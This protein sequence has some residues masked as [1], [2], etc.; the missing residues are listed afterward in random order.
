MS[1]APFGTH[2]VRGHRQAPLRHYNAVI[3]I[4]ATSVGAETL[5]AVLIER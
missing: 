1:A 2:D 3:G 4:W 5:S